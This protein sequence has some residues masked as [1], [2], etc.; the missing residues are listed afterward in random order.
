MRSADAFF[1]L[2]EAAAP[3]IRPLVAGL[4]VLD[5]APER[6]G[7]RTAIA[8]MVAQM[9]RLR[10]RVVTPLLGMGMPAWEADGGFDLDYHL[11]HVVLPA[12]GS[13][14]QLLE[15]SGELFSAPLD[16]LRPLWEAH[17]IEGLADRRAALLL[18]LHH[19]VMDGVGSIALFEALTQ[20]RRGDGVARPRRVQTSSRTSPVAGRSGRTACGR[21]RRRGATRRRRCAGC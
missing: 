19:A 10:Q 6:A 2:A 3:E 17:L 1:W 8:R 15:F 16:H 9:P 11:R 21:R 12:P 7:L 13:W 14:R 20:A 4:F 18:K 5:R